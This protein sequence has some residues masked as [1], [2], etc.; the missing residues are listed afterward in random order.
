MLNLTNQ[1]SQASGQQWY[2]SANQ[3][4]QH[5]MLTSG[6]SQQALGAG[7]FYP[8]AGLMMSGRQ[9]GKSTGR[10]RPGTAGRKAKLNFGNKL[11]GLVQHSQSSAVIAKAASVANLNLQ[12]VAKLRPKFVQQERERLYDDVMK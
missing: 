6:Y 4:Q 12:T 3:A 9:G 7:G 11:Q 10:R 1:Q 5:R 2:A 8:Q